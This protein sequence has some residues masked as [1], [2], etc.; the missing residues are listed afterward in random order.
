MSETNA[1]E[2]INLALLHTE[3]ATGSVL[4]KMVFLKI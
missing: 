1:R 2:I 4:E 3:A